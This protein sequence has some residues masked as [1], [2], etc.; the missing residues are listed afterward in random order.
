MV[1]LAKE[2]KGEKGK[3]DRGKKS[4]DVRR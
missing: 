2:E 4:E 1:L 3:N